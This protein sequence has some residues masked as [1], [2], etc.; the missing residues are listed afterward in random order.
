MTILNVQKG[1][2]TFR[3]RTF[4]DKTFREKMGTLY[5]WIHVIILNSTW[6]DQVHEN[7]PQIP[8]HGP[9]L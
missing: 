6:P 3:D 7:G 9:V 8:C 5:T 4:R 2:P 1:I